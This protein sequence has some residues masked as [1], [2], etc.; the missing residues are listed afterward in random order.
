M[1]L[2]ETFL[3]T[4]EDSFCERAAMGHL[5]CSKKKVRGCLSCATVRM[6]RVAIM[7][8][9]THKSLIILVLSFF[10]H[11]IQS[12]IPALSRVV[13]AVRCFGKEQYW[14]RRRHIPDL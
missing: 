11:R 8:I 9:L 1:C 5:R 14:N 13:K 12:R 2:L 3:R 6:T 7:Q 4:R 10:P